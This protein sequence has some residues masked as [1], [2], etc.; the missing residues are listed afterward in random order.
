MA[1]I[2]ENF[3]FGGANLTPGGAGVPTLSGAL[4]DV[5]DDL[6][7]LRTQFVA[8]LTKIDADSGDTYGDTN[9][10]A[11]LTPGVLLTTKV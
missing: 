5:A 9:Y 3:G 11:T 8:L 2:S 1:A 10:T 7:E 6:A 4:R